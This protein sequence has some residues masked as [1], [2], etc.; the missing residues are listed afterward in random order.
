MFILLLDDD[1]VA[2]ALAKKVRVLC[3]IMTS[4][5]NLDRK[6]IHV[7]NTW[8]KRCNIL[9]FMSSVKNDSFPTV[10]LNT[11]EGREHL[12]AKTMLAFRYV[13]ENYFDK[14]D[15]FLKADDDTYV[16]VENLRH[17]LS[18]ENTDEP[19]FFG[20][21]FKVIVKP[22]GYFSGGAGYI[23]SKEALRRFAGKGDNETLCRQ[24]GGAEDV[25]FG[26]CMQNLGIKAGNST[27]IL[28]RS[29]FHCFGLETHLHGGYPK[30][31]YNYD[32]RGAIKGPDS[33]SDYAIS[34]HY[35]GPKMIYTLEFYIYHLR[36]YGIDFKFQDLNQKKT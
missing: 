19:V 32:G 13:Y 6:A 22:Q 34:F 3:W 11:T 26:R 31:Y 15:W 36:P 14:A 5:W 12:T 21:Q 2:K 23:L 1:S 25:S 18:G 20:H 10:G 16:I 17:F 8:G 33:I 29:R 28:G 7:K 4:P 27:D 35:M 24:D 9:L 30:W